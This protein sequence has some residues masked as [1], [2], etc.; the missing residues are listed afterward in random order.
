MTEQ[1]LS[2]ELQSTRYYAT[3]GHFRFVS[4]THSD[5]YIQ[6]RLCL[7]KPEL[8][9]Q[10]VDSAI[11]ALGG[12]RPSAFAAFTVGGLLLAEA[13]S[14]A[15]NVPLVVGSKV[16]SRVDWIGDVPDVQLGQVILVDDV[17]TT[18][19]QVNPALDSLSRDP[20]RISVEGVIV[21]VYTGPPQRPALFYSGRPIPLYSCAAIRMNLYSP[22][23]C[24]LCAMGLPSKDLTNPDT[25][26][27]VCVIVPA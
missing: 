15:L 7:M 9:R 27:A 8:R 10:F 25:N 26:F 1:Q 6:A 5:S 24:P 14:N 23:E 21:A 13:L 11:H 20:R 19:S 17:L 16:G 22:S 4:G 18:P 12:F 3:G 2:Q